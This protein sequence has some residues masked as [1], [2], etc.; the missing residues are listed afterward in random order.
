MSE[1]LTDKKVE[2][3]DNF[4]SIKPVTAANLSNTLKIYRNLFITW[5]ELSGFHFADIEKYLTHG[6]IFR[7]SSAIKQSVSIRLGDK[8]IAKLMNDI[9]PI[10]LQSDLDLDKRVHLRAYLQILFLLNSVQEESYLLFLH[11]L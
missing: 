6:M 4:S 1:L 2:D 7:F 3:I 9:T 5:Y 10:S 8:Q 11:H